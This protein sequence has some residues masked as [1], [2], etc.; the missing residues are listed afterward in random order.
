MDVSP[1]SLKVLQDLLT[2]TGGSSVLAGLL[3]D[4]SWEGLKLIIGNFQD[5]QGHR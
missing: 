5:L 4:C 3:A 2:Q 1:S